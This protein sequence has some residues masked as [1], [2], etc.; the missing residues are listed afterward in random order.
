MSDQAMN[1]P[2]APTA[3]NARFSTPVVR[4]STTIPTP[5]RLYTPPRARPETMNGWKFCQSG[6]RYVPPRLPA[7]LDLPNLGDRRVHVGDG[8]ASLLL[9]HLA[10]LRY[11]GPVRVVGD[12][13]RRG[14]VV[15]GLAEDVG[16]EVLDVLD[17]VVDGLGGELAGHAHQRL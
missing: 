1:A 15:P 12:V 10:V 5:D 11:D 16:L 3:P 8:E 9:D 4:N 2:I 6:T 14:A 7:G 13:Q 17:R